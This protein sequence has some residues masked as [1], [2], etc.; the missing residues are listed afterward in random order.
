VCVQAELQTMS[1]GCGARGGRSDFLGAREVQV[2][3]I[4]HLGGN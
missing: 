2:W 1:S 3:F 4:A